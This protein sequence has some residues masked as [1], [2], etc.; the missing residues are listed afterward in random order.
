MLRSGQCFFRPTL[1]GK[2]QII[3]GR[4]AVMRNPSYHPGDIRILNAVPCPDLAHLQDCIVFPVW[5]N[6]PHPDEMSGGDL[7]GDEYLVIWDP[8]LIPEKQI[9]AFEYNVRNG[10][11]NLEAHPAALISHFVQADSLLLSDLNDVLL[12]LAYSFDYGPSHPLSERANQLFSFG[13]DNQEFPHEE[14]K[15]IKDFVAKLE[16]DPNH[17]LFFNNRRRQAMLEATEEEETAPGVAGLRLGASVLDVD[18]VGVGAVEV[19]LAPEAVKAIKKDRWRIGRAADGHVKALGPAA[20]ETAKAFRVWKELAATVQNA[21]CNGCDAVSKDVENITRLKAS[22]HRFKEFRDDR[23]QK[24]SAANVALATARSSFWYTEARIKQFAE[25]AT[26]LKTQVKDANKVCEYYSQLLRDAEEVVANKKRRVWKGMARE[27]VMFAI[28]RCAYLKRRNTLLRAPQFRALHVFKRSLESFNNNLVNERITAPQFRQKVLTELVQFREL[29][30]IYLRKYDIL[31][32]LTANRVILLVAETGAGKSTQV[33]QYILD[34]YLPTL[35]PPTRPPTQK[36]NNKKP[37]PNPIH[38]VRVTQPRRVAAKRIAER[39]SEERNTPLGQ[40]VGYHVGREDPVTSPSTQILFNTM[41][42]LLNQLDNPIAALQH[43]PVLCVDEAHE[44]SLEAD[45]GL[46]LLKQALKQ[47]PTLKLIIM[48][49]EF[50]AEV[51][52]DYFGGAPIVTVKGRTFGVEKRFDE[53]MGTCD[54]EAFIERAVRK[55]VEILEDERDMFGM[56]KKEVEV[57]Q[58]VDAVENA[59]MSDEGVEQLLANGVLSESGQDFMLRRRMDSGVELE[60][61]IPLISPE[62]FPALSMETQLSNPMTRPKRQASTDAIDPPTALSDVL[63][64]LTGASDLD[65]ACHQLNTACDQRDLPGVLP[66]RLISSS[67]VEELALATGPLPP[68]VKRRVFFATNFAETSLTFNLLGHVVD[69]GCEKVASF[70]VETQIVELKVARICKASATQSAGR[71]GRTGPGVCH[72]LYTM[73]EQDALE[74]FRPCDA[75]IG[76]S[77]LRLVHLRWDPYTFDWLR[78]PSDESLDRTIGFVKDLEMLMETGEGEKRFNLLKAGKVAV[79]MGIDPKEAK[80]VLTAHRLKCSYEYIQLL[81]AAGHEEGG[82][83][84]TQLRIIKAWRSQ[85]RTE[86]W[87]RDNGVPFSGLRIVLRDADT[88]L[89]SFKRLAESIS[90]AD[91]SGFYMHLALANDPAKGPTHGF[92]LLVDIKQAKLDHNDPLMVTS[93]RD[94]RVDWILFVTARRSAQTTLQLADRIQADWILDENIAA[95]GGWGG[96]GYEVRKELKDV[97]HKLRNGDHSWQCVI[98]RQNATIDFYGPDQEII[99]GLVQRTKQIAADIERKVSAETVVHVLPDGTKLHVKS[100]GELVNFELAESIDENWESS[101][102]WRDPEQ[103]RKVVLHEIPTIIPHQSVQLLLEKYGELVDK[104]AEGKISERKG[105]MQRSFFGT[106]RKPLSAYSLVTAFRMKTLGASWIGGIEYNADIELPMDLSFDSVFKTHW[107]ALGLVH[108]LQKAEMLKRNRCHI[109]RPELRTLSPVQVEQLYRRMYNPDIGLFATTDIAVDDSSIAGIVTSGKWI[110][111][112][113]RACEGVYIGSEGPLRYMTIRIWG[114]PDARQKASNVI[115]AHLENFKGSLTSTFVSYHRR[116]FAAWRNG[117]LGRQHFDQIERE[118]GVKI[119]V[120]VREQIVTLEGL[121]EAVSK[122]TLEL[123][124]AM[125]KARESSS[126]SQQ[127]RKGKFP[128]VMC[129]SEVEK[130]EARPTLCGIHVYHMDCLRFHVLE[131]VN[132]SG[133]GVKRIKCAGKDWDRGKL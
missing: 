59:I 7:D 43:C 104:P 53:E 95:K 76:L 110:R 105:V 121:E 19:Y 131:S 2:P 14:W 12:K 106:F 63:V 124:M 125:A 100:G 133:K 87:C 33:P 9:P 38:V 44:R 85:P 41:G 15:A 79:G 45:L 50:D 30:P 132:C 91:L 8:L 22:L 111:K 118:R 31:E 75:N 81:A 94:L 65:E 23:R 49:A 101:I 129:D 64:F 13:V 74:S 29:L 32:T 98:D 51:V 68:G 116:E 40:Q 96:F 58:S 20:E 123:K 112:W 127:P 84:L 82:A 35:D 99:D 108:G 17:I 73:C 88:L 114:A 70:N 18:D 28:S 126:T 46:A 61:N 55:V 128:C 97:T 72:R 5:G 47:I 119:S 93:S 86:A 27:I 52:S 69:S 83:S 36:T 71:V 54:P 113:N 21:Y 25:E 26:D 16:P 78:R 4:V 24:L 102:S 1:N 42:I 90:R 120:D 39:V 57:K 34:H 122:V 66:L 37:I 77:V 130:W 109:L 115:S 117:K 67:S 48:S 89:K 3:T 107:A 62:E 92:G 11:G 10:L 103:L 56:E 6:R 80:G 60:R